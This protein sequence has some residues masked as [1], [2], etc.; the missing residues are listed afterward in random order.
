MLSPNDT[1]L[2][3]TGNS[4]YPSGDLKQMHLVHFGS[5]FKTAEQCSRREMR[6]SHSRLTDEKQRNC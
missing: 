4:K 5:K 1:A 3:E 6:G 2:K